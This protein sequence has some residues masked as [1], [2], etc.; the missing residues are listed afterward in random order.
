MRHA[1]LLAI[2]LLTGCSATLVSYNGK[3]PGTS[4]PPVV[5]V[6]SLG[7]SVI[8]TDG[9]ECVRKSEK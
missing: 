5:S 9:S 4:C 1:I 7:N 6:Q 8:I 2:A 3:S